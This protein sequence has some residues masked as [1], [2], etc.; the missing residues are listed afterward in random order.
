MDNSIYSILL[1]FTCFRQSAQRVSG[2]I[3]KSDGAK[4]IGDGV[5]TAGFQL[6][7]NRHGQF[8]WKPF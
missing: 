6:V 4:P 8:H 1:Y 5:G 7:T 2:S 3:D